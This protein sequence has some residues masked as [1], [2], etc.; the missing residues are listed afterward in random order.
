MMPHQQLKLPMCRIM[1]TAASY[2]SMPL[3]HLFHQHRTF[4][5]TQHVLYSREEDW[6]HVLSGSSL[7]APTST[8]GVHKCATV[9][10]GHGSCPTVTANWF[11]VAIH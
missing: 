10:V 6:S 4:S 5:N 7:W 11:V 3:S 1:L 8:T 9:L 2:S